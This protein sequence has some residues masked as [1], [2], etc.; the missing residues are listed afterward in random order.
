VDEK[1]R[2]L[3]QIRRSPMSTSC[4]IL[5]ENLRQVGYL[6]ASFRYKLGNVSVV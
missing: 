4:R 1:I 2:M 3:Q 5:N 6:Q